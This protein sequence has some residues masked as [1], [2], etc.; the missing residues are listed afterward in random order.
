MVSSHECPY[1]QLQ[2]YSDFFGNH[3]NI[4]L[5]HLEAGFMLV[6]LVQSICSYKSDEFLFLFVF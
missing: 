2:G 4:E 6:Q 1:P 5:Y 3:N